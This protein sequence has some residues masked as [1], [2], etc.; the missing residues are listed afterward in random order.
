MVS[1]VLIS[2]EFLF[3]DFKSA[4]FDGRTLTQIN[5]A[6]GSQVVRLA[7]K[8]FGSLQDKVTTTPVLIKRAIVR[9]NEC[10]KHRIE[11]TSDESSLAHP[12]PHALLGQ[13]SLKIGIVRVVDN[14]RCRVQ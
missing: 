9:T 13:P 8:E 4:L 12:E 5:H 1:G 7:K 2:N 3:F 14:V 11:T 10:Y 6:V